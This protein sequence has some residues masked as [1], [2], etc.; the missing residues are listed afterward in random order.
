MTYW[1]IR[2]DNAW[3]Y[4]NLERI[5]M[6]KA[7]YSILR[8]MNAGTLSDTAGFIRGESKARFVTREQ[9]HKIITFCDDHGLNLDITEA[10]RINAKEFDALAGG[11]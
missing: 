7:L 4:T 9:V 10:R 6:I 5:P 11:R 8:K 3:D 2:V 1:E